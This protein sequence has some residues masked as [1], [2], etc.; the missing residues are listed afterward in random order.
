MVSVFIAAAV[1]CVPTVVSQ[2]QILAAPAPSA[3]TQSYQTPATVSTSIFAIVA[4]P[5]NVKVTESRLVGSL[6]L[7][8]YATA[9]TAYPLIAPEP[10]PALLV[11]IPVRDAANA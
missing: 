7:N 8:V 6:A 2:V 4:T 1:A 5:F 10:V 11:G 3:S 9:L